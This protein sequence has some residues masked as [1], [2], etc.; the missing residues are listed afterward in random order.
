MVKTGLRNKLSAHS[1][2]TGYSDLSA[3]FVKAKTYRMIIFIFI[4][5]M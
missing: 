5:D 3:I 4:A 2:L 1:E